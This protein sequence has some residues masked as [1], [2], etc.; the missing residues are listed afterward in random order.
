MT[1]LDAFIKNHAILTPYSVSVQNCGS[2]S[3]KTCK[4]FHD[5]E[6]EASNLIMQY[7]PMPLPDPSRAGHFYNREDIFKHF[8]EK[9]PSKSLTDLSHLPLN[10]TNSNMIRE[11][12]KQDMA[13]GE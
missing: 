11:K 6:G 3:C 7:Q 12:K 9:L 4:P 1:A 2:S 10:M 5:P 8:E 13:E